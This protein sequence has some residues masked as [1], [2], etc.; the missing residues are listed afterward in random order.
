VEQLEQF[1]IIIEYLSVTI[2]KDYGVLD[3]L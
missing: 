1:I 3:L 2:I